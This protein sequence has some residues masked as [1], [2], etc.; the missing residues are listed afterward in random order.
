MNST[1]IGKLVWIFMGLAFASLF[2]F[3]NLWS[4]FIFIILLVV[5]VILSMYAKIL[6]KKE[7]AEKY[8]IE[9]AVVVNR[10]KDE[11]I[12]IDSENYNSNIFQ[13]KTI[14][15]EVVKQIKKVNPKFSKVTFKQNAYGCFKKIKLA[16]VSGN[17]DMIRPFETDNMFN[18][19]KKEMKENQKSGLL[20]SNDEI[21]VIS[22]FIAS[23]MVIDDKEIIGFQLSVISNNDRTNVNSNKIRATYYMEFIKKS[24]IYYKDE[25]ISLN[26]PNCQAP[27][28]VSL[29]GRCNYCESYIVD[30][31]YSWVLNRLT[32]WDE[33]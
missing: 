1:K 12:V 26:C 30:G 6:E 27:L 5:I 4:L 20:Y 13:M 23:F 24:G 29:L 17:V 28:D 16:M 32:Y 21:S 25:I 10:D 14:E 3:T 2:I 31:D 19:H 11:D 9:D 7:L 22:S 15:E 8:N 18:I 33:R